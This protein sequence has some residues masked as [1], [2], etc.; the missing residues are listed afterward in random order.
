MLKKLLKKI[1]PKQ[2]KILD[3]ARYILVPRE[4]NNSDIYKI[5]LAPPPTDCICIY[6]LDKNIKANLIFQMI[7]DII[8]YIQCEIGLDVAGD[9]AVVYDEQYAPVDRFADSF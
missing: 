1:L 4:G 3:T 8:E 5:N 6:L 2:I 9:V 7:E